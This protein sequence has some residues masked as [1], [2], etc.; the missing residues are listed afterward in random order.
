M[1]ILVVEDDPSVT[2]FLVKGLREEGYQVDSCID[3]EQAIEQA[4]MF[5]YESIILDWSLPSLDGI[6]ALRELRS[7]GITTPVLVLTARSNI[8]STV[9]ALDAGAD[10]FMSKPFSFDELLA[11]LRAL[12]RRSTGTL[13]ESKDVKINGLSIDLR[14]RILR[15]GTEVIELSGREFAL[16]DYLLRER[17]EVLSRAR[18]LDRVWGLD[19]DP[20]TNVVDVY[21]RYLRQK[22]DS[23]EPETSVI[24]TVRGRGYRLKTEEE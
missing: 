16:L 5:E 14:A 11:R 20:N 21:I 13:G 7:R 2:R 4:T 18:I 9:F 12:S 19:H 23:A 24:E 3:G 17:G 15:R 6:S 10:D 22:L 1:L 8:P